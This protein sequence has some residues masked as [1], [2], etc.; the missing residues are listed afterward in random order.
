MRGGAG[1]RPDRPRHY[2]TSSL[3]SHSKTGGKAKRETNRREGG[4]TGSSSPRAEAAI[5]GGVHELHSQPV[6]VC[7]ERWRGGREEKESMQAYDLIYQIESPPSALRPAQPTTGGG[8]CGGE[9]G[10]R[11]GVRR[12]QHKGGGGTG[13]GGWPRGLPAFL[14]RQ[15]RLWAASGWPVL[16]CCVLLGCGADKPTRREGTGRGGAGQ[17]GGVCMGFLA[18]A[19][20]LRHF[21]RINPSPSVFIVLFLR[22]RMRREGAGGRT[23]EKRGRAVFVGRGDGRQEADMIWAPGEGG[24]DGR[25]RERRQHS[26]TMHLPLYVY[27]LILSKM[28]PIKKNQPNI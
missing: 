20:A 17:M 5:G 18:S 14:G 22:E 21:S 4:A 6:H 15:S 11:G 25:G 27:F 1:S 2:N 3:S 19:A 9:G 24:V 8:R 28:A 16:F 13:S 12:K 26:T 10:G 23:R 7:E